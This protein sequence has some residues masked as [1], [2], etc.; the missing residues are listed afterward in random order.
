VLIGPF[1][2]KGG[3]L[4][5]ITDSADRTE[6]RREA[7]RASGGKLYSMSPKVA[8]SVDGE[9]WTDVPLHFPAR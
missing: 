4:I 8:E 5:T 2:D 1:D 3:T 7:L 6:I 9:T